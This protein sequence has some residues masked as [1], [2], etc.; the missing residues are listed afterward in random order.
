MASAAH[1]ALALKLAARLDKGARAADLAR[2][3][4]WQASSVKSIASRARRGKLKATAQVRWTDE[5]RAILRRYWT[6]ENSHQIADRINRLDV[7]PVTHHGVNAQAR[8]LGLIKPGAR[9]EWQSD[10]MGGH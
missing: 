10:R 6:R 4:G 5:M 8:R 9:V 3:L 1:H 2:E 7:K